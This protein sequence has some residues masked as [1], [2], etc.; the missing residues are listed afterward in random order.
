METT[1]FHLWLGGI[2]TIFHILKE[3]DWHTGRK[4]LQTRF[5]TI[6]AIREKKVAYWNYSYNFDSSYYRK[7]VHTVLT[8]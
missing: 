6:L 3:N 8:S 4:L 7:T 5:C 2:N 1:I